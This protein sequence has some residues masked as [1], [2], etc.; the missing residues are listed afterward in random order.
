VL[1][2][3]LLL[4]LE[5]YGYATAK[6]HIGSLFN[7][8]K[9][10]PTYA[11]F[12]SF[13]HRLSSRQVVIGNGWQQQNCFIKMRTDSEMRQLGFQLHHQR[14]FSPRV[15]DDSWVWRTPPVGIL[16][17]C[18]N[19]GAPDQLFGQRDL[20]SIDD[21]RGCCLLQSTERRPGFVISVAVRS[22]YYCARGSGGQ[23]YEPQRPHV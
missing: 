1:P 9:R 23:G 13:F 22:G 17:F 20:H 7:S 14:G 5:N 19:A 2:C 3:I 18:L 6:G 15:G 4:D 8:Q 16:F 10:P 12:S 21:A 11:R